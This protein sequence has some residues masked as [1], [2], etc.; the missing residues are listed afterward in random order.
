MVEQPSAAWCVAR[1]VGFPMRRSCAALHAPYAARQPTFRR[2]FALVA[3]LRTCK[4][5][6]R[7]VQVHRVGEA[8]RNLLLPQ[9][10]QYI[11]TAPTPDEVVDRGILGDERGARALVDHYQDAVP[12]E[13][14]EPH[15]PFP[16]RAS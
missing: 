16:P 3:A 14:M 10:R 5:N 15:P 7:T 9:C 4:L 12:W 13:R 6:R 8:S 2:G 11:V 1:V